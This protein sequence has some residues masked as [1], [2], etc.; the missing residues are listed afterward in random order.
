MD[1]KY[2]GFWRRFAAFLIDGIILYLSL[3][4]VGFV[5]GIALA[6]GNGNGD[7][8]GSVA[9]LLGVIGSW[10][11][12]ALFESS[13]WQATPG[14]KALDL[15]VT[16]EQGERISFGRATGRHFSKIISGLTLGIGYLMVGFM[17]KK[18]GLHDLIAR[19]L[20]IR[21]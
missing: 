19:T 18:Q 2:G 12:Y 14:K 9:W 21:R 10:L 1:T 5:L 13:A 7:A 8:V 11:Y 3:F 20:V 17:D 4:M 6:I 15:K 16:T